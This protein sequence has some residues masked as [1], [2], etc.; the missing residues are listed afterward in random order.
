MVLR[1]EYRVIE[2]TRKDDS[3]YYIVDKVY[4]ILGFLYINLTFKVRDVV[5]GIWKDPIKVMNFNKEDAIKLCN[6]LNDTHI[7]MKKNIIDW[8]MMEEIKDFLKINYTY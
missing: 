3:M 5:M 6:Y 1:I 4:C 8:K 2:C 7:P